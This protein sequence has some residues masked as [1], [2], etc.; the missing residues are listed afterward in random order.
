MTASAIP[1]EPEKPIEIGD[2][3]WAIVQSVLAAHMQGWQVWA[4]GSR[5]RRRAKPFS[6]LDLAVLAPQPLTLEQ[7]ACINDAFDSSDVTI[8]VDV[9]DMQAINESFRAVI[10]RDKVRLQ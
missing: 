4:F 9:V 8:R 10:D 1:A 6:D 2:Q 3:D 7:L 5:A